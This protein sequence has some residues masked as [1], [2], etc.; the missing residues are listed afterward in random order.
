MAEMTV[1]LIHALSN[2]SPELHTENL[3]IDYFGSIRHP[4]WDEIDNLRSSSEQFRNLNATLETELTG[5]NSELRSLTM[6]KTSRDFWTLLDPKGTKQDVPK[7]VIIASLNNQDLKAKVLPAIASTVSDN[8]SYLK[9]STWLASDSRAADIALKW[10]ETPFP[11]KN[12]VTEEF[13]WFWTTYKLL[14]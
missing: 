14:R 1:R 4:L 8:V 12:E 10:L 11:W 6:N 13:T 7:K 9:L 5:L 2:S 3:L